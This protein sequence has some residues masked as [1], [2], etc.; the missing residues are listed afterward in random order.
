MSVMDY[1]YLIIDERA[2]LDSEGMLYIG[3]SELL[4]HELVREKKIS[5]WTHSNSTREHFSQDLYT[6]VDNLES[7][8]DETSW[9]EGVMCI[10][11][12]PVMGVIPQKKEIIKCAALWATVLEETLTGRRKETAIW[13]L[14]DQSPNAVDVRAQSPASLL[15][16]VSDYSRFDDV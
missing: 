8:F 16:W 6:T 10:L 1:R 9:H 2:L 7:Y 5:V 3:I 12:N 4:E 15:K 11:A 14:W 13:S